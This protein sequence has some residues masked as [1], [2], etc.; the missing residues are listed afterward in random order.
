MKRGGKY[1]TAW[2]PGKLLEIGWLPVYP[3]GDGGGSDRDPYGEWKGLRAGVRAWPLESIQSCEVGR[4]QGEGI[5]TLEEI[6]EAGVSFLGGRDCK[7]YRGIQDRTRAHRGE[8]Y[9]GD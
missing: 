3:T 8:N 9:E 4:R 6:D 5:A 7:V 1:G 2:I